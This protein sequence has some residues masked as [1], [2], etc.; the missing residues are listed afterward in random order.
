MPA[1]EMKPMRVLLALDDSQQ[2]EEA[3]RAVSERPWP[4]G[5]QVRVMTVLEP[6]IPPPPSMA[7]IML[8][9]RSADTVQQNERQ[10]AEHLTRKAAES[11]TTVQGESVV[12]EG[13]PSSVIVEEAAQWPADLIVMGSSG[14]GG[15]K[16][17]FLGSVSKRSLRRRL[18]PLSSF[19]P[20]K[21]SADKLRL[22]RGQGACCGGSGLV[23]H[24]Y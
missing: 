10:A 11:L 4:A 21:T 12:R 2:S 8:E 5:T 17:L 18:V 3:V 16:R 22:P 14:K 23:L 15:L 13:D 9:S 19:A 24:K 1:S 7:E 6:G 20:A